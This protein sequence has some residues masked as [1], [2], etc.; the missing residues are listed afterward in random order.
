MYCS[1]GLDL[2]Y[3]TGGMGLPPRKRG[4]KLFVTYVLMLFLLFQPTA[5]MLTNIFY[6][7]GN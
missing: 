4:G 1:Y 6:H 7:M 2:S 5:L 3:Y